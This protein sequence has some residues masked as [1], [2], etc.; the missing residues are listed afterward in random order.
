M[1]H[2]WE[3][4]KA[5]LAK[6][7]T[8]NSAYGTMDYVLY[9]Q[10]LASYAQRRFD[11]A[12]HDFEGIR[13]H[14]AASL[15]YTGRGLIELAKPLL[16]TQKFQEIIQNFPEQPFTQEAYFLLADS[17]FEAKDYL[18]ANTSFENFLKL[19]PESPYARAAR[20]KIGL[21]LYTRQSYTEARNMLKDA[22]DAKTAVKDEFSQWANYII[23][24]SYL[25]ENRLRDASFSYGT[26][27]S[28]YADGAFAANA[29]Y[30][31][32]WC[33]HLEGD[34]ASSEANLKKMIA[35]YPLHNLI[36]QAYLL[37]GNVY[38]KQKK[39][40]A[41]VA[42]YQKTV[43]AAFPGETA[44]AAMAL[45]NRAMV[46]DKNHGSL[47]S[48][49]H[50]LLNNYPPSPSLWR[51]LT[52]LYIAE[53]YFRSNLY[54]EASNVYRTI[55][56]FH[57]TSPSALYAQDGLAWSLF[58]LGRNE[59][60]QKER[61]LLLAQMAGA[62][63]TPGLTRRNDFE[64]G[65]IL[66]NQKKYTEA[67]EKLEKFTRENPQDPMTPEAYLRI[68]LC[69]SQLNFHGQAIET[70]ESLQKQ[71]PES[72]A[73]RQASWKIADTYFRAQKYDNAI[74]MY[75][76]IIQK[77]PDDN[78]LVLAKL[79]I[80]QSYFNA[81][82]S[83]K[84]LEQFQKVILD[85]PENKHAEESLDFLTSL[86]DDK[87]SQEQALDGLHIIAKMLGNTS[88]I[89]AEAQLRVAQHYFNMQDWEKTSKA[90]ED[91]GGKFLAAGRLAQKEYMLGE[92]YYQ[93]GFHGQ[94]ASA[95]ERLTLN[96]PKSEN[97]AFAL[98]RIGGAYF[99]L[100]NY[101]PAAFAFERITREFPNSEYAA[102]AYFN[103]ALAYKKA[104]VWE[105]AQAALNEYIKSFPAKAKESKAHEELADVYLKQKNYPQTIKLYDEIRKGIDP[106]DEH[107]GEITN[108]IAESYLLQG[109][110]SSAIMEYEKVMATLPPKSPWRVNA[111][112]KLGDLYEKSELWKEAVRV[113]QE[114]AGS[115]PKKEWADAARARMDY[116]RANHPDVFLK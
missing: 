8:G 83:G 53:A 4:A 77:Y 29:L 100:D 14:S 34:Y 73:T 38:A 51:A 33:Y 44:E 36:P 103:A 35:S 23:G 88:A 55:L 89:G 64:M 97:A 16:A 105:K 9:L 70:W 65:N 28:D 75:Q 95:F 69:Y 56:K 31:L 18:S 74:A 92:A 5:T 26:V 15:F 93:Q 66:F 99:K 94:A 102:G 10:G 76:D 84:A 27:A 85:H 110:D 109:S 116:I 60:A 39:Y 62:T 42:A 108:L 101:E 41:A 79:R 48:G 17:F 11:D 57:P 13:H 25:K 91:L 45:A 32:S 114:I 3:P 6:L 37:L 71:F 67:L 12:V 107:Y 112:V 46:L 22:I 87:K 52:Y 1:L 82:Q 43:D 61:N 115:A 2:S 20:Y 40:A 47:I 78:E 59:E 19:Y 54:T 72:P 98:F 80:A 68:G 90:L 104:K 111:G 50:L 49:Y 24:E 96:F 30:K 63:D 21:G 81:Q 113:Y 106:A 58:K 7:T 86:L